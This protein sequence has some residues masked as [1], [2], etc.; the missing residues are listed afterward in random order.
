MTKSMKCRTFAAFVLLLFAF[1]R[2]GHS[3]T[4]SL[5]KV[6]SDYYEFQLREDP[7][8][9]T[10]IGRAEYDDRWDDPSPEHQRQYLAALQEFLRRLQRIPETGLA[11]R[12][13]L[14][15]DLLD[16]HLKEKIEE[17]GTVSTFFSVNHLVG[18][19]L[20]IFST[21]AVAP[22]NTV[23]DYQNEVARLRALPKW[24]DQTIG[25]ADLAIEQKKVQPKLVAQREL[26]ELDVE[27]VADPLKSPLLAAFTRFPDSIPASEQERLRADA[28]DAYTHAFL[29][30]W[31]KLRDY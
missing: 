11:A 16:R 12:D 31:H 23:K 6:F 2:N 20:G 13:R 3:Q 29:P 17:A 7:G 18:E 5:Q 25:A 9:A 1:P 14:S 19:H 4:N 8:Q 10:F 21:M 22:A 15:Y 24:V 30:A 28:V 26:E 27:M